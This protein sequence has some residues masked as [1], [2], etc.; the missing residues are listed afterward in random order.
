[1]AVSHRLIQSGRGSGR[2]LKRYCRQYDAAI[3]SV[4]KF[5]MPMAIDQFI[6][7]PSIDPLSRKTGT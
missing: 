6:I 2:F 7:Q 5:V 3:F 1:M 4:A